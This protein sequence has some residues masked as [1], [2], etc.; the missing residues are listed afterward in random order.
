LTHYIDIWNIKYL[1]TTQY[2]L[3]DLLVFREDDGSGGYALHG[4]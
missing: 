4:A 3:N 2:I 1:I